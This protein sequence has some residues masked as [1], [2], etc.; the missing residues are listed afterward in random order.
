MA[1]DP[2]PA[3]G[4]SPLAKRENFPREI[5][6]YPQQES[7]STTTKDYFATKNQI[8]RKPTRD[9]EEQLHNLRTQ[10]SP[11]GSRYNTQPNSPHIAY[12]ERGRQLSVDLSERVGKKKDYHGGHPPNSTSQEV[13]HD[14]PSVQKEARSKRSGDGQPNGKFKLQEVPKHKKSDAKRNSKG[15]S[16]PPTVDTTVPASKSKS[17]PSSANTPLREQQVTV[18]SYESPMSA[19]SDVTTNESPREPF[20]TRAQTA[21]ESPASHS[22][23]LSTQ[24]KTLPARG[25]SLAKGLDG[26]QPIQRREIDAGVSSKLSSAILSSLESGF[27]KPASAPPN[28]ANQPGLTTTTSTRNILRPLD[29]P[30]ITDHLIETPQ[31]PLRAKERLARP[32]GHSIMD[33]SQVL[34][35]PP[36][37]A[38]ATHK[39]KNESVSTLR[40]DG[41]YAG[42]QPPSPKILRYGDKDEEAART[43]GQETHTEGTNFLRRVSQSV[44]HARSYSDRGTRLSREQKWPKSPLVGS[45]SP[46]FGHEIGSPMHSS[47]ETREEVGWYK[48]ELRKERQNAAERESRLAELE[49]ALEARSSIKQMNTELREKRSTMV[50]LDT[51]KEIVV[52]ELEVL[53]EHI[54]AAKKTGEPLDIGKMTNTVLREFAES[55]Q[56]LKDSF[57]PQI[58]ELTQQRNEIMEEVTNLTQLKDQS[59]QEFEQLSVKNAQLADLNNQLVHQI[60]ELYK[61]NAG[62]TLDSVRPPPNGLGIHS[63]HHKD[64]A[65]NALSDQRDTRP[66]LAESSMTGSTAVPDQESEPTTYLAAPQVVNIRKAQPKKFNWKKGGQNVAK[67]VTKGLKG[68]FSSDP[69]R[70]QRDGNYTEGMP[71]GA[72][73]QQ[74]YPTMTTTISA[75]GPPPDRREGFGGF[76][77][78]RKPRPQQ[79]KNSPNGSSPAVHT[80]SGP[81]MLCKK[82]YEISFY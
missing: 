72:M 64:K 78:D 10:E 20:G 75:R 63:Q 5:F 82:S 9:Q 60:Q 31:P 13:H 51:Q 3:P 68:A 34:R 55:L 61:A 50:V 80:E 76:F 70:G 12:Q 62:P 66:S 36:H 37:T 65:L 25:D 77:S 71:Y 67:G 39:P 44:R 54:A 59:F 46:V 26:K 23:P 42:D 73:S 30:S 58:E 74:D 69:G 27:D 8:P 22:S 53:T 56:K 43:P 28:I 57:S 40:S 29:S 6:N 11:S 1:F 81:R 41:S 32:D 14:S 49:A 18:P 16:S 79:W 4:P 45:Q 38:P 7:Q 33:S 52:R 47:P 2:T 35:A 21:N 15:G 24:L 17:A 48:N 19:R